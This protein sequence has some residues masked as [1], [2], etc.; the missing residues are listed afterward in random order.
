MKGQQSG[1]AGKE[2]GSVRT[3]QFQVINVT[4]AVNPE[5][6]CVGS[7]FSPSC[8]SCVTWGKLLKP[9]CTSISSLIK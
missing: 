1:E 8:I 4:R 6:D 3:L 5:P 7:N 9:L 2:G